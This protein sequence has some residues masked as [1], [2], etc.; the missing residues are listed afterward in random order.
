MGQILRII[1]FPLICL[2]RAT[3]RIVHVI[4]L[5]FIWLKGWLDE[6]EDAIIAFCFKLVVVTPIVTLAVLIC[7]YLIYS[8]L[9][10]K[11]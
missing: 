6:Y 1:F 3:G 4:L 8:L 2:N 10:I 7:A 5:P 9:G 11:P